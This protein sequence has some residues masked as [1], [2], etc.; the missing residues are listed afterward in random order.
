MIDSLFTLLQWLLPTGSVGA[1]IVW[2]TSKTLRQARTAKEVHDTYKAM[3]EDV[4]GT[5]INLQHDN[6]QL[7]DAIL[8]LEAT[9][10]RATECRYYGT[11]PL[12]SELQQLKRVTATS[13]SSTQVVAQHADSLRT[14]NSVLQTTIVR[15]EAVRADSLS[16]TIPLT[17]LRDLPQGA[18][19]TQRKGRAQVTIRTLHDTLYLDASCDSLQQLVTYYQ[20]RSNSYQ[21]TAARN[22]LLAEQ[23]LQSY[24][25]EV[26]RTSAS[27]WV[28]LVLGIALVAV[29]LYYIAIRSHLFSWL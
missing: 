13:S 1:V 18:S 20:Q 8:R 9:I 28:A 19:Y 2:L 23:T 6:S 15:R 3:Y 27:W 12:R 26:K 16:M 22:A 24:H 5:L 7:H 29:L 11:C 10:R 17:N 14:A 4:Q 25:Q 21:R